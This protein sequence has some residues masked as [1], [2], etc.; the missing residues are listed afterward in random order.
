MEDIQASAML[1]RFSFADHI[2][3]I[4]AADIDNNEVNALFD[5]MSCCYEI[6]LGGRATLTY[7]KE[8][9]LLCALLY[10][11]T[12]IHLDAATSGQDFSGLRLIQRQLLNKRKDI[13]ALS[14]LAN[15]SADTD[16]FSLH[17]LF[18][19]FSD[20]IGQ[21][22]RHVYSPLNR[23]R[24]DNLIMPVVL[25]VLPYL[26]SRKQVVSDFVTEAY[27]ALIAEEG[28]TEIVCSSSVNVPDT[29]SGSDLERNINEHDRRAYEA[30]SADFAIPSSG[31]SRPLRS[32]ESALTP[33]F[34]RLLRGDAAAT[35][36]DILT[37]PASTTNDV[38]TV[39]APTSFSATAIFR[40]VINALIRTHSSAGFPSRPQT[41]NTL[42]WLETMHL[43]QFLRNGR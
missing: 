30:N 5:E 8:I 25:S 11:I 21:P 33:A 39:A 43:F 32:A 42:G 41:S 37:A 19:N 28:S 12:S 18:A 38:A 3:M 7:S 29:S 2:P 4:L 14:P 26:N 20:L 16:V 15:Q 6:L 13:S 27:A 35:D 34:N 23:E 9:K 40:R 36:D 22:D 10:N 1:K 17:K 31:S 24:G